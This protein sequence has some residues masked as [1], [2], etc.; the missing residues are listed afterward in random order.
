[1]DWPLS[2]YV[3]NTCEEK[4]DSVNSFSALVAK[5]QPDASKKDYITTPIIDGIF[6]KTSSGVIFFSIEKTIYI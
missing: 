4:R 6:I 3:L 5:D 2:G 1:M